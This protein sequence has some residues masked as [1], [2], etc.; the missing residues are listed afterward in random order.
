MRARKGG[1]KSHA[2]RPRVREFEFR[3]ANKEKAR[4]DIYAGESHPRWKFEQARCRA[5]PKAKCRRS[6]AHLRARGPLVK[7]RKQAAGL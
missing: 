3:E 2:Y 7:R 4:S 6:C 1:K 5:R